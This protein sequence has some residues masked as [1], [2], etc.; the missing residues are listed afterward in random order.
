MSLKPLKSL[1]QNFLTDENYIRKIVNAVEI[2]SNDI[3]IEIGP[4]TGALTKHFIDKNIEFYAIEKDT[5]AYN[6]LKNK[7]ENLN[8]INDDILNFNFEAFEKFS[9]VGNLPYYITSEI[10]YRL[11]LNHKKVIS[12]VFTVQK[13]VAERITATPDNKNYGILSVAVQLYAKPSLL[14]NIP[15]G[16]FYPA[17]K[18]T[19]SVIHMQFYNEPQFEEPE[20][21]MKFIKACFSQ[22][23]KKLSNS[24]KTYL[25]SRKFD[26]ELIRNSSYHN[27]LDK[28]AENLSI[29]DFINLY[30]FIG[31]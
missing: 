27:L 17:P 23:R 31:S 6:Y 30:K 15:P 2:N 4:G 11:L 25:N 13:E 3:L 8:I 14:F 5:R 1:G 19:S 7:Y 28:R 9:V 22:R 21:L 10:I 29:T 24:L 18:V 20:L 16:A 26:I 12:G